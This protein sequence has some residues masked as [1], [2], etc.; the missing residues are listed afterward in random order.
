MVN[1]RQSTAPS[2]ESA[3]VPSQMANLARNG[4]RRCRYGNCIGIVG[5]TVFF[6]DSEFT[7]RGRGSDRERPQSADM[8]EYMAKVVRNAPA[9]LSAEVTR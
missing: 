3:K 7:G 6:S 9:P 8:D 2:E 4:L 5:N 1:E